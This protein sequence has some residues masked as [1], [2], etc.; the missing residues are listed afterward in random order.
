MIQLALKDPHLVSSS[1]FLIWQ[2]TPSL[3]ASVVLQ[4]QSCVCCSAGTSIYSSTT[5]APRDGVAWPIQNFELKS[6]YGSSTASPII[7]GPS[8]MSLSN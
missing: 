8:I 3:G 1:K 2:V 6:K 5:E 4:Q 7:M